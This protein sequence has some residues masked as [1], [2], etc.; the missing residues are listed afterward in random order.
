MLK[1]VQ[2]RLKNNEFHRVAVRVTLVDPTNWEELDLYYT[3]Q[4]TDIAKKWAKHFVEIQAGANSVRESSLKYSTKKID[5][6]LTEMQTTISNINVFYDQPIDIPVMLDNHTLNYLHEC[7]EKYGVRLQRLLEEKYWDTAYL[8]IPENSFFS[9]KWPGIT[10]DENMHSNF[11]R[12]NDLIHSTE[13]AIKF[14][15]DPSFSGGIVTYSLWPRN[16]FELVDN[17]WDSLVKYPFFGDLCL[18]Y[19]TLGKNLEHIVL[20]QDHEAIERNA[21]IPQQT[22]S[23]EIYGYLNPDPVV[24]ASIYAPTTSINMYKKSW[25]SLQ[26]TEKLGLTFGDYKNNKEGYIKIAE[27]TETSKKTYFDSARNKVL[28]NFDKFSLVYKVEVVPEHVLYKTKENRIPHWKYVPAN[29]GKQIKSIKNNTNTNIITWVLNNACTYNCYYCPPSLHTGDNTR[30]NW[31]EV[32]PFLNFI[33]K[34]YGSNTS[35]S[36][37]GGEPTISPF[38]SNL[39][40]KINDSGAVVGITTNLSRSERH[41]RENFGYLKYAACSFHPSMVFPR[42]EDQIFIDKLIV[43]SQYT[44]VSARV[45]MD[46]KFWDETVAFIEKLKKSFAGSI[47][48]VWIQDQYGASSTKICELSYSKEQNEFIQ[49]F[50]HNPNHKLLDYAALKRNS[51]LT[52][53]QRSIGTNYVVEYEDG[54][55]SKNPVPQQ[56]INQAETKHFGWNC[57]IG[58][59][60]LFISHDGTIKRGNCWIGGTIGN[61]ENYLDVDW[62]ELARP[63]KC[64][65]GWCQCGADVP[66][67]KEKS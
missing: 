17:D 51:K 14:K 61:I 52:E 54:T 26:V 31:E 15:K 2:E 64:T 10:F 47:S 57:S 25:D 7:Y 20:D 44:N 16:D 29:S 5:D 32:E 58:K 67:S 8:K 34:Q 36:L 1:S 33:I 55:I 40:R 65:I 43:A 45:M 11:I 59:E 62:N 66:I 18:G 42:G 19:N 50:K 21:I 13:V 3:L 41:I 28:I 37:S 38:F 39:I 27:M 56:L 22:W 53:K 4:N 9:K 48:L 63:V 60:S 46:P 12:L 49:N 35:F 24:L 23:T 30:W 6:L